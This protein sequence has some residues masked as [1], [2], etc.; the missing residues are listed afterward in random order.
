AWADGAGYM[1]KQ[2]AEATALTNV[3]ART[4]DPSIGKFLSVDPVIDTNLP[5][6]NTGYAY[7]GNNPTTFTDPTGLRLDQGC[8]WG[9]NCTRN[10]PSKSA[11]KPKPTSV[12]RTQSAPTKSDSCSAGD[13]KCRVDQSNSATRCAGAGKFRTCDK[14]PG[15]GIWP[16]SYRDTALVSTGGRFTAVEAMDAFKA[17]PSKIFPFEVQ[18]CPTFKTGMECKLYTGTPLLNPNGVVGL[19]TT[20]TSVNFTVLD[21]GYFD[22][23]GSTIKFSTWGDMNGNV[24]L[25]RLADGHGAD[26]LTAVSIGV[27]HAAGPTWDQ[28]AMNLSETLESSR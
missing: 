27:F 22:A 1:N 11:G 17:N 24:Y 26:A 7:A 15:A 5:Q 13:W 19:T 20:P 16:Y 3:G 14:N 23:P 25:T 28:Q 4:Y 21:R 6:Q 2:V 10:S 9:V 12:T 18:G 8:G